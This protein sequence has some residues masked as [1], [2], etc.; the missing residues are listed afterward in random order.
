MS[1]H[2]TRRPALPAYA[3]DRPRLTALVQSTEPGR[4]CVIT[5]APGYGA[6]TLLAQVTSASADATAWVTLPPGD[7]DPDR[8]WVCASA[9]IG[10]TTGAPAPTAADEL[11]EHLAQLPPLWL[12]ID[13]V[14][15]DVDRAALAELEQLLPS[16]PATVR[17]ALA[18]H[19]RV[20]AGPATAGRV[21]TLDESALAFR[22]EEALDLLAGVEL[23]QVDAVGQLAD[24]WAAALVAAAAQARTGVPVASWLA[25]RGADGLFADWLDG[26]PA[27]RREFLVRT[28]VLDVLSAGPCDAVLERADSA[29]VLDGLDRDHCYLIEHPAHGDRAWRRHPLLTRVLRRRAGGGA[30]QRE[31]HSRAADW[32]ARS[33][34]VETTMQH[35]LAAGRAGDAGEFLRVHEA[36]LLRSGRAGR[37]LEWY[38]QLPVDARGDFLMHLLRLAWG[39]ALSGDRVAAEAALAQAGAALR[40]TRAESVADQQTVGEFHLLTAYLAAL[41]ADSDAVVASAQRAVT[42]FDGQLTADSHQVAPLL[43]VRGLQWSGE[44]ERAARLLDTLR[45]RP[46]PTDILR[47]VRL[48]GLQATRLLHEGRVTDALRIANRAREWM[49]AQGLDPLTPGLTDPAAVAALAGIEHG[50]RT[51]PAETLAS[52]AALAGAH[53][54][55]GEQV[56]ALAGVA[57]LRWA[58]G[59]AGAAVRAVAEARDGLTAAT[60]TSGLLRALD[61]IE[62]R[63]R[64][65]AGDDA[66]AER[67]LRGLPASDERILLTT[68]L[69]LRRRTGAPARALGLVQST[70]PRVTAEVHM[71]QATAALDRSTRMAEAHLLTAADLAV[72]HGLGLLLVGASDGMRELADAAARRHSHDGLL[73]LLDR[74][75]AA[76]DVPAAGGLLS[77]GERQLLSLLPGRETINEIAAVLS[78]SPNTVKTR[79]QRLYRKLGVSGRNEAVAAA[80]ARALLP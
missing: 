52:V 63:V 32:F 44:P 39:Q 69:A 76:P 49:A 23:A 43:L 2:A 66:R 37:A 73:W 78:V 71:L 50:D 42:A 24:G 31:R 68:R 18:A 5:S 64:I 3:V 25:G 4:C 53:G 75:A 19:R 58:S 51:T 60:P 74:G 62:A 65:D 40:D 15:P 1:A 21:L 41:R 77:A 70:H 55:V 9:A 48:A 36:D 13:G 59:D 12:V 47:E 34:D 14:D 8:F 16:L 6:T 56:V 20:L 7:T 46:F 11:I 33:D 61:L 54:R 57:R 79:L 22:P 38:R 80:R 17:L 45:G 35:L 67:L 28:S 30:E 26:L 10:Q 29:A 27:D 72:A